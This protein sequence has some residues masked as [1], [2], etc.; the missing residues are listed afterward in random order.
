MTDYK[1]LEKQLRECIKAENNIISVMANASALIKKYVAALNWVG[2]YILDKEGLYPGPF[3]GDGFAERVSSA[4]GVCGLAASKNEPQ[5][6]LNVRDFPGY[7]NAREET[8]S[9]LAIPMHFSGSVVA[10]LNVE[11]PVRNRFAMEDRDCLRHLVTII[12]KGA[13]FTPIAGVAP[14]PAAPQPAKQS[15]SMPFELWLYAIKQLAQTYEMVEP[16]YAQLS[17]AEKEALRKEYEAT[18]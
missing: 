15:P 16:I 11:S 2:F 7:I 3:Q 17:D 5:C 12:E 18:A 4:K 10:V 1:T 14:K 13:D 6:A 9:E 8:D